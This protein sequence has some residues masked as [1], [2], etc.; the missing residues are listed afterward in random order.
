MTY[1]ELRDK[2]S[3]MTEEEQQQEVA[4][5]GEDFSLRKDCLLMKTDGAVYF[6]DGWDECCEE[7]ELE[8]EDFENPDVYKVCEKGIYYIFG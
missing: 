6:S 4:I 8:P 7:D 2:I 5:W 1:K 3:H